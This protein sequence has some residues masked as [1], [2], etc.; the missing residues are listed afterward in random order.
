MKVDSKGVLSFLISYV[1]SV[2]TPSKLNT[3]YNIPLLVNCFLQVHELKLEQTKLCGLNLRTHAMLLTDVKYIWESKC[4]YYL[5]S[6]FPCLIKFFPFVSSRT[7]STYNFDENLLMV[8]INIE[9]VYNNNLFH[10]I[11]LSLFEFKFISCLLQ[12]LKLI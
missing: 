8:L 7:M 6:P 3:T 10:G 11:L 2:P 4:A 5:Y 1:T 12:H 9:L